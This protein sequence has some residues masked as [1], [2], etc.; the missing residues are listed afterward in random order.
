MHHLRV[1]HLEIILHMTAES[2]ILAFQNFARWR[3]LSEKL[4]QT[5][6]ILIHLAAANEVQQIFNFLSQASPV[7]PWYSVTIVTV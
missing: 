6:H 5:M 2:S 4:H 1:V 3:F 7:V